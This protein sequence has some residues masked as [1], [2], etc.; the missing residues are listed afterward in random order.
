MRW[1]LILCG[2]LAVASAAAQQAVGYSEQTD[3]AE[4][5]RIAAERALAQQRFFSEEA[6]CYQRFAV[7]DCLR[8]VRKRRRVVLEELRRQ[9][10]IL[11]DQRRAA[12]AARR[13][14]E[15]DMRQAERESA[16]AQAQREQA[17]RE[18]EARQQRAR[19]K[20]AEIESRESNPPPSRDWAH[21]P[22]APASAAVEV[23]AVRR[24]ELQR[25][26]EERQREAEERRRQRLRELQERGPR[27]GKPLPVPP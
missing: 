12:L 23:E 2:L 8:A 25:A 6:D 4:R 24:Q 9:E 17:L 26:Y 11:N 3:A 21:P 19:D 15:T 27:T 22:Q 16:A 7:N 18:H 14:Q 13:Q 10:L 1:I 20:Q 5:G